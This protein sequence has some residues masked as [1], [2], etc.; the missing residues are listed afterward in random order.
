MPTFVP[1]HDRDER[2][3]LRAL[4]HSIHND[5]ISSINAVSAA[6]VRAENP[7]VKAALGNVVELLEH[8]EG[9]HRILTMPD[10]DGLVDA[11]EYVRKLGSAISRS[12]LE[13]IGIRL[14]L[15]SDSLP[16][17]SER[18][19]RLALA[20][21]ELVANAARHA[22]F[23]GRDGAIKVKLSLA[24]GAVNCIVA[25]GGSLSARLKPARGL[26][27]VSDLTRSL[28]GRI[29]YGFGAQFSSI[30]LV[31]PLTECERRANRVVA[32][33]RAR[34]TRQRKAVPSLSQPQAASADRVREF[35]AANHLFDNEQHHRGYPA[36]AVASPDALRWLVPERAAGARDEMEGAQELT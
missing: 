4:T 17:E 19:W 33:R 8:H 21:H 27:I 31:F 7:D 25:D 10:R 24:D 15:V 22:C 12:S 2:T 28:G 29:Q 5:L 23:D 18:C 35:P 14:T 9:V 34:A 26:R 30:L 3:L 32:S 1:A 13:P 11:A 6:A 20:I 16:L 36:D